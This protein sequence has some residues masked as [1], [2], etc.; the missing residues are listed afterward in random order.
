MG[1]NYFTLEKSIDFLGTGEGALHALPG[2]A[3]WRGSRGTIKNEKQSF[4]DRIKGMMH[5]TSSESEET[6]GVL[7]NEVDYTLEASILVE[8]STDEDVPDAVGISIYNDAGEDITS[9]FQFGKIKLTKDEEV[10]EGTMD[11]EES[12]DI[13][14]FEFFS[15]WKAGDYVDLVVE[16]TGSDGKLVEMS[17]EDVKI[18]D[19]ELLRDKLGPILRDI[20]LDQQQEA[21]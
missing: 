12:G 1:L 9:Q 2:G 20:L 3:G 17:A 18:V 19:I 15:D 5:G 11:S 6:D 4:I 14:V 8:E 10:I 7:M 21:A 16:V 13:V